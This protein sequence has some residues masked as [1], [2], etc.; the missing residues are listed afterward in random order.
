MRA[1]P[2]CICM[3]K[4]SRRDFE[5]CMHDGQEAKIS[6]GEKEYE[7]LERP[8]LFDKLKMSME[9]VLQCE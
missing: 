8:T 2:V 5:L 6:L 1:E 9:K 4:W 3:K 7:E